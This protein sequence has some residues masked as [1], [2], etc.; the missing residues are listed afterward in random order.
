MLHNIIKF[1]I[2]NHLETSAKPPLSYGL[3]IKEISFL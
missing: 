2:L 3:I 1:D